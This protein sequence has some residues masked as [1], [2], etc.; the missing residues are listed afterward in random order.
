MLPSVW[1]RKDNK[2]QLRKRCRRLGLSDYQFISTF[3]TDVKIRHP[4]LYFALIELKTNVLIHWEGTP[5]LTEFEGGLAHPSSIRDQ[6]HPE[7][8]VSNQR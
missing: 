2:P 1:V 6:V 3:I 4:P 8:S 7:F 5:H